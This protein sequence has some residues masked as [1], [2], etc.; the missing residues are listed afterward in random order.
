MAARKNNKSAQTLD[1][2]TT[3]L[4]RLREDNRQLAELLRRTT[5][6]RDEA[7]AQA[8]STQEAFDQYVEL[9][10]DEIA[11]LRAEVSRKESVIVRQ[12][13]WMNKY[14]V[15]AAEAELDR[16]DAQAEQA[17]YVGDA[18]SAFAAKRYM[19]ENP[20]SFRAG[21]FIYAKGDFRR[22]HPLYE[23]L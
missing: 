12:T 2:E 11:K 19:M 14:K 16:A 15:K 18:I 1:V 13:V 10:K 9:S 20:G 21:K 7:L 4:V 5:G 22:E 8:A 17:D 3:E 6:Q 23:V